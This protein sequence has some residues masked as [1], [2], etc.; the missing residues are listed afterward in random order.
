MCNCGNKRA[1]FAAGQ[2]ASLSNRQYEPVKD[3]MWDDVYFEYTGLTALSI[4]GKI[5]GKQYRFTHSGNMQLVDYRDA[6][7]MM[8]IPVL[9]KVNKKASL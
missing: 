9:R 1:Q 2:P 4:T 8:A 3:K 6:S 7:G 5:S